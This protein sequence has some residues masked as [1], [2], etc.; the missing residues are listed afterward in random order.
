MGLNK[1]HKIVPLQLELVAFLLLVYIIWYTFVS[2]ASLPETIPTHFNFEG[3]ADGWG[4]KGEIFIISGVGV[5][6]YLLITGVGVALSLV[7]DPKSLI[8]LPNFIK[9]RISAEKAE[10]LRVMMVRCLYTLKLLIM[11]LYSF[12]IYGS[13]QTA[14]NRWPGLGY[15]PV[16]FIPLILGIAFFMV[17]Y[18][19]RLAYSK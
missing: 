5:F 15:W 1:L 6:T 7:R 13:I 11:G 9:D 17:Y 2:F 8:N 18:S 4:G 16:I 10:D 3:K 12:L 19:F 14:L